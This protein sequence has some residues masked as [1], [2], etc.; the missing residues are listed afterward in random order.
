[1]KRPPRT[2]LLSSLI[3]FSLAVPLAEAVAAPRAAVRP[4]AATPAARPAVARIAAT[5]RS[6]ASAELTRLRAAAPM[7]RITVGRNATAVRAVL[8]GALALDSQEAAVNAIN[9]RLGKSQEE[10]FLDYVIKP[11]VRGADGRLCSTVW[12]VTPNS[13]AY[14]EYSTYWRP[15]E[16]GL[17]VL[18]ESGMEG[19]LAAGFKCAP[20]VR[21]VEVVTR[22]HV[23]SVTSQ[24]TS[25]QHVDVAG[26]FYVVAPPAAADSLF[27]AL[28]AAYTY[29]QLH[30]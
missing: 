9:A 7:G 20:N 19:A 17:E 8:G 3:F 30:P 28:D 27:N 21:C 12:K 5:R 10:T 24:E 16:T 15:T 18:T 11:I 23:N 1:M 14:T 22:A 26:Y 25:R 6:V 13:Q 2:L 4:A 29:L